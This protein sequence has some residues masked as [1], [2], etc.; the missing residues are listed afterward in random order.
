MTAKGEDDEKIQGLE[1][2]GDDYV[3]KP[4]NIKELTLRVK[5]QLRRSS[6]IDKTRKE[7]IYA[8]G[9]VYINEDTGEIKKGSKAINLTAKELL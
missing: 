3:T 8:F 4:F 1:A 9:D 7:N 6:V 2:G 5:A